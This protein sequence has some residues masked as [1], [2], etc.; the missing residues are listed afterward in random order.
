MKKGLLIT[1][2]AVVVVIVAA[3]AAILVMNSDDTNNG[4]IDPVTDDPNR[5]YPNEY[6]RLWI[7]GNDNFDD[8]LD[9]KD[10]EWIQKIMDGKA[11]E[12][13]YNADLSQWSEPVRMADANQ[14]GIVNQAD[15]PIRT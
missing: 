4:V 9:E 5:E 11:N 8:V 14:D 10:I 1:I 13:V 15:T 12:V 3:A 7:V 2:V 6:G